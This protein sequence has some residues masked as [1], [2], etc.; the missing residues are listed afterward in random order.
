MQILAPVPFMDSRKYKKAT[1]PQWAHRC[2]HQLRMVVNA[3]IVA[4]AVLMCSSAALAQSSGM[5]RMTAT[6]ERSVLLSGI[7]TGGEVFSQGGGESAS[8]TLAPL[9]GSTAQ[10][11]SARVQIANDPR[12]PG[13]EL[14]ARVAGPSVA[15]ISVDGVEISISDTIISH[16]ELYDVLRAHSI[17]IA[18]GGSSNMQ[19]IVTARPK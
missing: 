10:T 11:F 18:G 7:T 16:H 14:L 15:N 3:K 17:A 5:L 12:S 13:Y 2:I 6:V 8:A 4:V 19:I 9:P 1:G